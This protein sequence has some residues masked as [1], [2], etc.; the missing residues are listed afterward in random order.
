MAFSRPNKYSTKKQT[1]EISGPQG[2]NYN[3]SNF[4]INNYMEYHLQQIANAAAG[5]YF[6]VFD[7]S[8][9]PS[10]PTTSRMRLVFINVPKGPVNSLVYIEKGDTAGFKSIFGDIN[11]RD[12]R[13]GNFSIR[14][15]LWALE[16]GPILVCNLRNFD[17]VKDRAG[18]IGLSTNCGEQNNPAQRVP[19]TQLFNTER[20]WWSDP[21]QLLKQD[22]ASWLNLCNVGSDDISVFVRKSTAKGYDVSI[23]TW[24]DNLGREMPKYV[25]PSDYVSDTMVDIF[26]FKTNFG[27]NAVNVANEN[28]GYLFDE[29]GLKPTVEQSG[30]TVDALEVLAGITDAQYVGR[31][32]GSLIPGMIDTNGNSMQIQLAV[33]AATASTGL[34]SSFN[35]PEAEDLQDWEPEYDEDGNQI[36]LDNKSK[37]PFAIDLVGHSYINVTPTGDIELT[38]NKIKDVLGY[39]KDI[40]SGSVELDIPGSK[41]TTKDVEN[42]D[43]ITMDVY[44]PKG[45]T[46]DSAFKFYNLD[47]VNVAY[48]DWV[49]GRDG[50]LKRVT[51]STALGT[52]TII[53]G[54][55][56]KELPLMK[57]GEIYPTNDAGKYVYPLVP[58]TDGKI[59]DKPTELGIDP[60]AGASVRA[61]EDGSI[62]ETEDGGTEIREAEADAK[63]MFFPVA[64]GTAFEKDQYITYVGPDFAGKVTDESGTQ[65]DV[66]VKSN[67]VWKVVGMSAD[68]SS[69][70]VDYTNGPVSLAFAAQTE[71]Q[72]DEDTDMPLDQVTQRP[73]KVELTPERKAELNAKYGV[74]YNFTLVE[75][76]DVVAIS[77]IEKLADAEEIEIALDNGKT[78]KL[79]KVQITKVN[80]FFDDNYRLNAIVLSAYKIRKEQF[81]NGT[82]TRQS[83]IL[84]IMNYPNIVKGLKNAKDYRPRYLIDAFKSFIEPSYKY[85]FGVLAKELSEKSTIFCRAICNEAF[86]EDMMD[87]KNP[88]FRKTPQSN[89][90]TEYV[91]TGGN[92]KLPGT[93]TYEKSK[94]GD[95]YCFFFGPGLTVDHFGTPIVAPPAGVVSKAF[96]DKYTQKFPYTIVAN[97]TG[98]LSGSNVTGVEIDLDQDDRAP[99]ERV[100]YNPIIRELGMGIIIFGNNTAQYRVRSAMSKIHVS[101]L[102]AFIQ[103]QM[104]AIMKDYNFEL[105]DYQNRLEIKKRADEVMSQILDNG[106]VLYYENICDTSNNTLEIIE[107][108]MG[109]LDTVIVPG[110]GMEKIV[111]RTYIERGSNISG[112]ELV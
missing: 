33:N 77:D 58:V 108:D 73:Y 75:C 93:N 99:L 12:E 2:L 80:P 16:N 42:A 4:S 44:V 7:N 109:I 43:V 69:V 36:F 92:R 65:V 11:R 89:F 104:L 85:Q 21:K 105:N 49:V 88:Y 62:R 18:M 6:L 94:D 32:T 106:G 24:F 40:K 46:A 98:I 17:D 81:T 83:E 82:N 91:E 72:F 68:G 70:K 15:C 39:T 78:F 51:R 47:A 90:S 3:F 48:A 13:N 37:R 27:N 71:V 74:E 55:G 19:Y 112:F 9:I 38:A 29:N 107:N 103:E 97:K 52:K 26:I 64:E 50:N 30:M 41:V 1:S 60:N 79:C 54:I 34:L 63:V 10:I 20:L 66:E 8:Q 61:T 28:Y 31:Y 95:C 100:G 59:A 25:N 84:D 56:T 23:K 76:E 87:S 57:D 5:V 45:T 110:H 101:E 14:T 111:H 67:T 102:I 96:I 86:I 22:T 53:N 35:E